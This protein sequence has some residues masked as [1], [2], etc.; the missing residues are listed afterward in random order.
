MFISPT[1]GFFWIVLV[2]RGTSWATGAG[3][4]LKKIVSYNIGFL[5]VVS[6]LHIQVMSLTD[7]VTGSHA[8]ILL[9][10]CMDLGMRNS[11]ERLPVKVTRTAEQIS[12]CSQRKV[13]GGL[14][15]PT[16]RGKPTSS[17]TTFSFFLHLPSPWT[18]FLWRII[19]DFQESSKDRILKHFI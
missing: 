8:S 10:K 5:R 13:C 16:Q 3:R 18:F 11:S 2:G 19:W 6:L 1:N 4:I 7:L 9:S 12:W 14:T 15:S 17:Y